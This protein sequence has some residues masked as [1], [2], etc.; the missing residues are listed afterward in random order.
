MSDIDNLLMVADSERDA[1]M[2]YAVG[3]FLPDPII[4]FRID[5]KC[6]IVVS[7]VEL[8]RARRKARHCRVISY[9]QCVEKLR[10]DG[11]KKPNVAAVVNLL[12]RER[13]TKKIL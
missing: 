13:D 11:V 5:G 1:N 4:Y 6:H 9:S 7:D 12:L 2:L 10:R 8:D 3:I